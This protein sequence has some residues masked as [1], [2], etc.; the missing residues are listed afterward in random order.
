MVYSPSSDNLRGEVGRPCKWSAK[1]LLR[2]ATWSRRFKKKK[3]HD[4]GN[5]ASWGLPCQPVSQW[6]GKEGC[7]CAHANAIS[8]FSR[9][10]LFFIH[11]SIHS[12][13]SLPSIPLILFRPFSLSFPSNIHSSTEKRT[14]FHSPLHFALASTRPFTN[15]SS[16]WRMPTLLLIMSSTTC[17]GNKTRTLSLYSSPEER[18][19]SSLTHVA[20]ASSS[21]HSFLVC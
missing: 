12:H 9:P 20:S 10:P 16:P 7:G 14:L 15:S 3:D 19:T 4:T 8:F 6:W 5:V 2:Q 17:Q 1:R 21:S 18:A 11:P 13:P